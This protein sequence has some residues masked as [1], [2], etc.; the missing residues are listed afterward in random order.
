MS[1]QGKLQRRQTG[2]CR[3]WLFVNGADEIELAAAPASSADVLIQDIED[4]T[5]PALRPKAREL[6]P[7]IIAGWR[8]AG[9]VTAVRINPLEG[10]GHDD[11]EAVMAGDGAVLQE[12]FDVS[13]SGDDTDWRIDLVPRSGRL[14]RQLQGM[15]VAGAGDLVHSIRFELADGEWQRLELLHEEAPGD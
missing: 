5:P 4:F 3:S 15:S 10:D 12:H 7:E 9:A 1:E 2:L 8:T 6:S 13:L 14:A 11:I